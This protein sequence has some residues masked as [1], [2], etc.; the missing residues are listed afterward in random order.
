MDDTARTLWK[1]MKTSFAGDFEQTLKRMSWPGK[2]VTLAG[3]LEEE[4]RAG[5]E[6]LL[7]LQEPCVKNLFIYCFLCL[8]LT[9]LPCPKRIAPAYA[10]SYL[11]YP[12]MGF[13][14]RYAR[15]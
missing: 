5:V 8:L 9:T 2:D 13:R 15:P 3:E 4:W 7:D 12:R 1:Q 6:K 14:I 11:V 10:P